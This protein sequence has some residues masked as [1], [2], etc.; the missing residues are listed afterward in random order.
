MLKLIGA[1]LVITGTCAW[2]GGGILRL[3]RHN[4]TLSGM[5]SALH[6][7]KSEIC[8]RL[9][10]MPE[11]AALLEKTI[12]YPVNTFFALVK[13]NLSKLGDMPFEEIWKKSIEGCGDLVLYE[14]EKTALIELG[15]SL[16]K[17]DIEEQKSAVLL[18]IT[19]LEMFKKKAEAK[20]EHDTR[21]RA[22]LGMASGVFAVMILL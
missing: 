14:H 16:G 4:D 2:S 6:I 3:K 12:P 13:K 17:Y 19:R 7:M 8:V 5:I 22:V 9:S 15:L 18:A 20:K 1:I 11:V 21:I 10:T